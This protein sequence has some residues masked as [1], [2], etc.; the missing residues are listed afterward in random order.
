M[1]L[2]Y[3]CQIMAAVLTYAAGRMNPHM[4]LQHSE[5]L[6]M[7]W[8]WNL[9]TKPLFKQVAMHTL[10]WISNSMHAVSRHAVPVLVVLDH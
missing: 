7:S 8:Q 2:C 10:G 1:G 3:V 6:V 5:G 4:P 9:H